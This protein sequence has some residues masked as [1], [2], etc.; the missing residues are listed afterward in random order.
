MNSKQ[1]TCKTQFCD[2]FLQTKTN[3]ILAKSENVAKHVS[4]HKTNMQPTPYGLKVEICSWKGTVK[5]FDIYG[6]EP[7]VKMNDKTE[8]E[9]TIL[10]ERGVRVITKM[11]VL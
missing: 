3:Y 8:H 1:D 10:M 5:D 2:L 9:Q 6:R 11:A 4:V 7:I